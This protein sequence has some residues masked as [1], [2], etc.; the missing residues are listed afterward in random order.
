MLIPMFRQLETKYVAK[1]L[2]TNNPAND[3]TFMAD[4]CF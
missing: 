2:Y 3:E 1:D 4:L